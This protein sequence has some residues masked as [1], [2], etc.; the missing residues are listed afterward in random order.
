L[1]YSRK[2]D[3]ALGELNKAGKHRRHEEI[4]GRRCRVIPTKRPTRPRTW[5]WM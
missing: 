5:R 3:G 1:I 4:G 2:L